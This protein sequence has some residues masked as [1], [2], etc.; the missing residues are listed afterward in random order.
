MSSL[1]GGLV[2]SAAENAVRHAAEDK[3]NDTI[4]KQA[5]Q[6]T[7]MGKVAKGAQKARHTAVEAERITNVV[8]NMSHGGRGLVDGIGY[9]LN[10][11]LNVFR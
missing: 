10:R 3:V 2:E 11:I 5:K 1:I 9:F 8:S 6:E 7:T 4:D